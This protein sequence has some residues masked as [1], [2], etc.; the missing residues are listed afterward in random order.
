VSVDRVAGAPPTNDNFPQRREPSLTCGRPW[1]AAYRALTSSC[2]PPSPRG[3]VRIWSGLVAWSCRPWRGVV[4]P[5]ISSSPT[6]AAGVSHRSGSGRYKSRPPMYP[7]GASRT[8][9]S[10]WCRAKC[11]PHFQMRTCIGRSRLPFSLNYQRAAPAARQLL[12]ASRPTAK[13]LRCPYLPVGGGGTARSEFRR[14]S[15]VAPP[16]PAAA[17]GGAWRQVRAC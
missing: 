16:F 13:L 9:V 7:V 12:A 5:A 14:Q 10:C 6:G 11:A 17:R 8:R 3:T 4:Q 2:R 15:G 1:G